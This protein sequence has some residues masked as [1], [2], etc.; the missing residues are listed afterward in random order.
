MR[1]TELH[2]SLQEY[3]NQTTLLDAYF[4]ESNLIRWK[5]TCFKSLQSF[6]T[7]LSKAMTQLAK[8][9]ESFEPLESAYQ[10]ELDP[11]TPN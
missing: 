9:R 3:F 2:P 5:D 7:R 1:E 8:F 10:P 11:L 4:E 6:G